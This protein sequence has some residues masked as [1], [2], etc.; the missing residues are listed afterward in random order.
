MR[1][2]GRAA[3]AAVA[4]GDHYQCYKI[5]GEFEKVPLELE[6]QF[7]ELKDAE[8]IKPVLLCNPTRKVHETQDFPI[9]NENL[10]YVCYKIK[11][12]KIDKREVTIFNQFQIG[13]TL[14]VIAPKM[15]CVPSNK[16]TD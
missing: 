12:A 16:F 8:A 13:G 9:Q 2:R 1:R 7:A 14:K 4:L 3:G 11:T 15:L 6:D 5:K 10:H